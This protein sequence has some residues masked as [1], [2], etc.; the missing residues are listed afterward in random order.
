ML[1][2]LMGTYF[3]STLLFRRMALLIDFELFELSL[4]CL[5]VHLLSIFI[6]SF[7]ILSKQ[8]FTRIITYVYILALLWSDLDRIASFW[9]LWSSC[10]WWLSLKL[11]KSRLYCGYS[12]FFVYYFACL[13]IFYNIIVISASNS[14]LCLVYKCLSKKFFKPDWFISFKI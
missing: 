1:F 12:Y 7:K 2:W 14:Y 8:I 10:I 4:G 13:Q 3:S 5:I 9:S 6:I 11:S